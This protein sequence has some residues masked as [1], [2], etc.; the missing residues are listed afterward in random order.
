MQMCFTSKDEQDEKS[1]FSMFVCSR[2]RV[3]TSHLL[4][5]DSFPNELRCFYFHLRFEL[6]K[7]KLSHFVADGCENRPWREENRRL[8]SCRLTDR[9][10]QNGYRSDSVVAGFEGDSSFLPVDLDPVLLAPRE[11]HVD[12]PHCRHFSDRQESFITEARR[13]SVMFSL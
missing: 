6:S 9:K 7:D 1:P 13:S 5:Q 8:S 3:L 11:Q 10:K 4:Q 12:S 2:L